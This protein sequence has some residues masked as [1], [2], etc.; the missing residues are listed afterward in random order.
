MSHSP[1]FISYAHADATVAASITQVFD[2][3]GVPY[4]IDDSGIPWGARI[5]DEITTAINQCVAMVVIMSE[6][7]LKSPWV[8]YEVGQTVALGK[9]LLLYSAEPGLEI[10]GILSPYRYLTSLERLRAFFADPDL[11]RHLDFE[12]ANDPASFLLADKY[13]AWWQLQQTLRPAVETLWFEG[14]EIEVF[15]SVF[16]PDPRLTMSASITA[17]GLRQRLSLGKPRSVLDVGTGTGALAIL[18]AKL[19]ATE[20]VAVDEDPNAVENATRNVDRS[21]LTEAVR[22]VH[23]DLFA[24][25]DRRFDLI[26]ANLPISN[27]VWPHLRSSVEDIVQRFVREVA[28]HLSDQGTALLAWASFGKPGVV[29]AALGETTLRSRKLEEHSFGVI[30]QLYELRRA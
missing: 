28:D 16:S 3:L 26:V 21:G 24:G 7:S 19:G 18:A 14:F 22:V 25:L 10:P 1:V 23:G 17:A 2:E 5:G 12:R 8:M 20:V 29:E 9:R 13:V 6:A 15:K 30:W 11:L 4:F 27:W